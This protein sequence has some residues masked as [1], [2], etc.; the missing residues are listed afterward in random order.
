V[1]SA[2]AASRAWG[3]G[4][5]ADVVWASFHAVLAAVNRLSA[6]ERADQRATA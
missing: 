1:L 5:H 2:G 3:V 6:S 4:R